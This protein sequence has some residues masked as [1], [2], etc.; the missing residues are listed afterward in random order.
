ME[1]ALHSLSKTRFLDAPPAETE[2]F[3]SVQ[4]SFRRMV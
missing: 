4:L 3:L 2:A 1:V